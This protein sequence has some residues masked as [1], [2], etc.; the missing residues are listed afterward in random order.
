MRWLSD[1]VVDRLHSTLRLPLLTGT[2]YRAVR[3]LA[4]GGM[5]TVWLAEDTVLGRHVALKILDS[6]AESSELAARL[7]REAR[8]LARLEHPGIVPVH[9]AGVLADGRPYYSMKYVEGQR[10]DQ[11]VQKVTALPERLRLLERIAEPVAFAHSK[12]ILHRDLKPENIMIG[13]FGEV[14]VLDWGVAKVKEAP[15]AGSAEPLTDGALTPASILTDVPATAHG[16]VL[17]TRGYMSPEQERGEVNTL[18]ERTD[19]FGSGAILTFMLTGNAPEQS[20]PS[21]Q[22]RPPSARLPRP[23]VAICAK[24]TAPDRESRYSSVRQ[25]TSDIA[26]YLEGRPVVAYPENALEKAGRVFGRHRVAIVLVA[27]YLLMRLFFILFSAR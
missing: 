6:T 27:A 11:Y 3:Y 26:R 8:I 22:S 9:D 14:L 4:R 5:G 25:M 1:Q 15:R 20:G 12:G 21:A 24:A 23:L 17:G 16:E 18:D 19:V 2:R 10:L 7:L 13:S